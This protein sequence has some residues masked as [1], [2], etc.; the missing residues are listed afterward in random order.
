MN[1]TIKEIAKLCNVSKSTVSRYLNGGSVS[2]ET[3]KKISNIIRE[4][5]YE[6]N[7]FA[8]S[9]KR[10]KTGMVGVL[11]KG[12]Q[13]VSVSS[14]LSE[15]DAGLKAKKY[16]PLVM[17]ENVYGNVQTELDNIL[18]LAKQGVEGIILGTDRITDEHL[19]LFRNINIPIMIIGQKNEL[20]YYRKFD[21]FNAGL[22]AG[23]YL[24]EMG[25]RKLAFLGLGDEDL[26]V[27][28][29]RIEGI[30]CAFDELSLNYDLTF[31]QA[32]YSFESGYK[33]GEQILDVN[34]SVVVCSTDRVA[35]GLL[36]FLNEKRIVVPEQ[37][38]LFG[39]GNYEFSQVVYPPL[40]TIDFDYTYF[41]KL[42][43]QDFIKM[44]NG[45]E[46]DRELNVN[47]I[48]LIERESVKKFTI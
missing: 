29:S 11:F 35:M 23:K 21:N 4:T 48:Q 2:T 31:V 27:G 26:E 5:G 46:I 13:S 44:L 14:T 45:E 30:K 42:I 18:T 36:K 1:V 19:N 3:S 28:K 10:K 7:L 38:S 37:I 25:H 15:I 22:L 9:L 39:F 40:S 24:A 41:S 47:C 34:P 33:K 17:I 32:S 6:S 43:V 8:S 20:T 12:I 16:F